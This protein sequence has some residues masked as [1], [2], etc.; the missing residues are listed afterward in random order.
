M[1]SAVVTWI[2]FAGAWLLVAGPIYQA[3]LELDAE[4][5]EREE[6]G[7]AFEKAPKPELYSRWWW[8]I[9][10]VGYILQLRRR[11]N[12]RQTV[13]HLLTPAQQEQ[14][15]RFGNK[16]TGWIYIAGGAFLVALKETWSP[17]EIYRW[18]LPVYVLVVAAMVM[19]CAANTV[20]RQ[21]RTHQT[22]RS[23]DS[24]A[25]RASPSGP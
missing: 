12:Y 4:E 10:P 22:L 2:G 6:I 15:V 19:T 1:T 3:A 9:P 20:L 24:S 23:A 17:K 7:A 8:C 21:R 25:G 13:M 11:R 5:V 18:P 14:V 16:A